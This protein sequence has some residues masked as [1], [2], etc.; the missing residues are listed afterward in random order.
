VTFQELIALIEE[1]LAL[2]RRRHQP[3]P[4]AVRNL[5]VAAGVNKMATLKWTDPIVDNLGNPLPA[6]DLASINVYDSLSPTPAVPIASVP[7]TNGDN[8]YVA[9]SLV[10]GTH[11]FTVVAVDKNGAMGIP[12]NVAT[13]V[14]V[15]VQPAPGQITNLTVGP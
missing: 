7:A 3:P 9:A 5:T 2:L 1:I 6:G 12:S 15:A 8:T 13:W 14:E 11:G 10:A 4:G